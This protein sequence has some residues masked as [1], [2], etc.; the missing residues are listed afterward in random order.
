MRPAG[1]RSP[2]RTSGARQRTFSGPCQRPFSDPQLSLR[3]R[4]KSQAAGTNQQSTNQIKAAA[5]SHNA[6]ASA[7]TTRRISSSA[8]AT[9][10]SSS[11]SPAT[12]KR[13]AQATVSGFEAGVR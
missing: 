4:W 13:E 5:A 7:T 1:R 12:V 8:D 9:V 10:H 11:T 2:Q 6:V 3:E